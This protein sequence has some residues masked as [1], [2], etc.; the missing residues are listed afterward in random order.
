[1]KSI[2]TVVFVLAVCSTG[3]FAGKDIPYD[4][5]VTEE[6]QISGGVCFS[7]VDVYDEVWLGFDFTP[8]EDVLIES[9]T[10]DW[11]YEDNSPLLGDINFRMYEDDFYDFWSPNTPFSVDV[12][13]VSESDTGF[14]VYGRDVY[15]ATIDFGNNAYLCRAGHT[16]LFGYH[17][18]TPEIVKHVIRTDSIIGDPYYIYESN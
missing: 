18:D 10:A 14:D 17:M 7:T 4:N 13:D 16:Y 15:R 9:L 1:M 12:S 3:A 2:V 5:L 8:V 11:Y 6:G